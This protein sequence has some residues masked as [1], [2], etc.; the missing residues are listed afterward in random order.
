MHSGLA[1]LPYDKDADMIL[2]GTH[3]F[4]VVAPAA[5]STPSK[6]ATYG[7]AD[8]IVLVGAMITA[9]SGSITIFTDYLGFGESTD[10]EQAFCVSQSIKTA[11]YPLLTATEKILEDETDCTAAMADECTVFG[12][13]EGG[14]GA[15][16]IADMLDKMGKKLLAVHAGNVSRVLVQSLLLLPDSHIPI[17][18]I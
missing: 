7:F 10:Y 16:A 2:P 14:Y 18:L 8:T 3:K 9:S 6:F 5:G 1:I 4:N 15:I 17:L 12:Y 13:S 11:T